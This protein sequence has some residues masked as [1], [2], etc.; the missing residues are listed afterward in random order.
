MA[1][2]WINFLFI[3][4]ANLFMLSRFVIKCTWSFATCDK[5]CSP[6]WNSFRGQALPETFQAISLWA[7]FTN[8]GYTW[9]LGWLL[10]FLI[11]GRSWGSV[12]H[13]SR[14]WLYQGCANQLGVIKITFTFPVLI[15]IELSLSLK[16]VEKH[17]VAHNVSNSVAMHLL[18]SYVDL[19]S[20]TGKMQ[21][22]DGI[23]LMQNDA[24]LEIP[25]LHKFFITNL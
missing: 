7:W 9:P 19:L 8:R 25:T 22:S 23:L 18:I 2:I 10:M 16:K 11:W 14:T 24:T 6:C 20:T 21:A 15:L 17:T 4:P 12:T 5:L 13:N 1:W 3:T